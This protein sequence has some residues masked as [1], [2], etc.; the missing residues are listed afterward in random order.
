MEGGSVWHGVGGAGR[1]ILVYVCIVVRM[2]M[3]MV[4][5]FAGV[6]REDVHKECINGWKE[7]TAWWDGAWRA[8]GDA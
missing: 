3:Q 2:Y 7:A 1:A 6:V 4:W 5:Y 8:E